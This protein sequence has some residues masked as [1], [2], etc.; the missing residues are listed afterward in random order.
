MKERGEG[1]REE[2]RGRE[3]MDGGRELGVTDLTA[4]LV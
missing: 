2:E 4:C 3:R 1:R